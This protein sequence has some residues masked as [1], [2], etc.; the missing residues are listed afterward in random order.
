ML[1][2]INGQ[3]SAW[4]VAVLVFLVGAAL[5]VMLALADN[6]LYQ[7]QLRQRFD[8]LAAERFSRLQERLDRQVT[9]LDTLGRFFVFSHQ[10]EQSEFNGF[11]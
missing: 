9:R 5:T 2:F 6:E 3:L 4:P 10:V 1:S 7:R 8:M 11:V